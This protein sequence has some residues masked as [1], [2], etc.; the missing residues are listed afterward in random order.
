MDEPQEPTLQK[1]FEEFGSETSVHGMKYVVSS[2][3][4]IPKRIMW[5]IFVLGKRNLI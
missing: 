2:K 3:N 4:G 1:Q 5:A